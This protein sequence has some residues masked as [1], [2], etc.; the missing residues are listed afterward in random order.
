MPGYLLG[1]QATVRS[2]LEPLAQAF[3]FDTVESDDR[4]VF[5]L[6]ARDPVATIDAQDLLP[7]DERT[8]EGWRERRTQELELR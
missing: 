5:R 6:R 8:G 1:R 4:L 7:M 3:F 2:A